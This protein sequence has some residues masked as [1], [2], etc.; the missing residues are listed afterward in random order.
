MGLLFGV[1]GTIALL[2]LAIRATAVRKNKHSRVS[3]LFLGGLA[4]GVCGPLAKSALVAPTLDAL[5]G[6]NANWLVADA[7]FAISVTVATW[8]ADVMA[9]PDLRRLPMRKAL[10]R[11]MIQ[12][13]NLAL[14]AVI[15]LTVAGTRD[16]LW[17]ALEVGSTDLSDAG[18]VLL[19]ARLAYHALTAWALAYV[20]KKIDRYRSHLVSRREYIRYSTPIF[21][22]LVATYAPAIQVVAELLAYLFSL[23]LF[24]LWLPLISGVQVL[25][26][27]VIGLS[28]LP[29]EWAYRMIDRYLQW[30]MARGMPALVAVHGQL[31]RDREAG[32]PDT[33]L[34]D[35]QACLVSL[36][37]DPR[38][39]LPVAGRRSDGWEE[40]KAGLSA[41]LR[42][43]R[44]E[45]FPGL[46]RDQ[47]GLVRLCASTA[48]GL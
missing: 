4:I 20:A 41:A 17:S 36:G 47:A 9:A 14:V 48:R 28:A 16:P 24:N 10:R 18:V 40:A 37:F 38:P 26:F 32:G 46:P 7:L 2:T 15:G 33:L 35:I 6:L 34:C 21:G 23:E 8:W 29:R 22:L 11:L 39:S 27:A 12:K 5:L 31:C 19:L 3:A 25:A 30:E 42:G 1:F 43:K 45:A 44:L 13:R